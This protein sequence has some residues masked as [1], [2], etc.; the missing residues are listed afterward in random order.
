MSDELRDIR[1]E[2]EDEYRDDH[3]RLLSECGALA[4]MLELVVSAADAMPYAQHYGHFDRDGN[5][6][7][8]CPACIDERK[9][10][11]VVRER[12][13]EARH[14]L[15]ALGQGQGKAQKSPSHPH[16]IQG[17]EVDPWDVTT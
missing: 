1:K 17:K 5:A 13:T 12:T 3:L 14:L 7:R 15:S 6:G 16:A 8:T 11:D 9:Q 4:D 10:R 2:I